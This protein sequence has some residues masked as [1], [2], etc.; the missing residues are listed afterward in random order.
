[1]IAKAINTP[2]KIRVL[3][4][5]LYRSAKAKP[6]RLFGV[7]YDKMHRIDILYE[8]WA[9][10]RKNKGSAGVDR[11]TIEYIEEE[12]GVFNLLKDIQL[13][14]KSKKYRPQP[15][16]RVYIPKSDGKLRP[17]GIPTVKDRIVQTAM[18]LVIEPIFEAKFKG[19]SYGF[20]PKRSC[21]DAI[22]EI[23][24]YINYGCRQVIDA[25][26]KGY[27]D[28]I[29]HEKLI[30]SVKVSISDRSIIKLIELWLTCGVMEELNLKKQITGTPQGGVISPLLANIYL[31]WLDSYWEKAGF[32]RK[33]SGDAHLIRYA[34]D[35][36]ILCKSHPNIYLEKAKGVLNKLGLA[37]HENKTRVVN[38]DK[39][40][41]FD[42]LGFTF[43]YCLNRR[44]KVNP[45]KT[46]FYYPSKKSM[47]S[48]RAKLKEVISVSQH[49]D[50]TWLCKEKLNPILR[51]WCNYFIHGN[52]KKE[53]RKVDRYCTQSLCIMLKK[54]HG[55]RS[56]GWRD[57]P[58]SFFYDSIHK[59]YYMTRAFIRDKRI[60]GS[61]V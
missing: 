26:I 61:Y 6:S 33:W 28:S 35:F 47:K 13:Q 9:R 36:V 48:I 57:H 39:D 51:G 14:L 43:R 5:K 49:Y 27:F 29:D 2:E 56:K 10:V 18:K 54:K 46:V 17:L 50:L 41:S 25:D 19:F 7:L 8:S 11:Q 45:K 60:K 32:N 40:E 55:R 24:K 4:I 38:L 44:V 22:L 53:M 12:I 31:H 34:D 37:L 1:M 23:R 42:F 16:K 20:R 58:P 21:K 15:V 30:K 3:Q 59:L 52:S